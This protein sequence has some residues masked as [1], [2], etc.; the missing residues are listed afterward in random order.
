[1]L[2]RD[3][4]LLD[5]NSSGGLHPGQG[6]DTLPDWFNNPQEKRSFAASF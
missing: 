1:M 6:A 4:M 5:I 3:E 2:P